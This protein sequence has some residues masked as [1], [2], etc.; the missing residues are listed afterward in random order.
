MEPTHNTKICSTSSER[1][2]KV[3]SWLLNDRHL[4]F[5]GKHFMQKYLALDKAIYSL[6]TQWLSSCLD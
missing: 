6:A 5:V 2:H 4:L 1:F 3:E